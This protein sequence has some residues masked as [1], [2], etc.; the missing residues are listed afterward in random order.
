MKKEYKRYRPSEK[1]PKIGQRVQV[2]CI[3]EMIYRGGEEEQ[4]S[5][6]EDD[7]EGMRGILFWEELE[8]E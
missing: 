6:W 7:G 3:K 5:V 2:N 4:S 8:N 1:L